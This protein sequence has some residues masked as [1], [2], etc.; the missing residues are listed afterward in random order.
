MKTVLCFGSENL[1][2]DKIA[3]Q[4]AEKI[5]IDG[6]QFLKSDSPEDIIGYNEITI[7][8]V[9]KGI[10][11]VKIIDVDQLKDHGLVS[12]HDFDIGFFLSLTKE[13]GYKINVIGVP[14]GSKADDV[15]DDVKN[16]LERL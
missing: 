1:E 10:N 8:D 13:M 4:L 11:E 12:L 9:A 5:K 16:I 15:A 3:F 6:F 14:F 2:E 7:L